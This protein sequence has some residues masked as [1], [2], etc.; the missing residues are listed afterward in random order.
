MIDIQAYLHNVLL[1][2]CHPEFAKNLLLTTK[3]RQTVI[4]DFDSQKC[5]VLDFGGKSGRGFDFA[6]IESGGGAAAQCRSG[7]SL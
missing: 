3:D 5:S 7:S 6:S 4:S 1:T 2:L